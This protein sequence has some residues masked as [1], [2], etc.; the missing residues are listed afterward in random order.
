MFQSDEV[1]IIKIVINNRLDNLDLLELSEPER[2]KSAITPSTGNQIF[3]SKEL[4]VSFSAPEGWLLQ[5]PDQSTPG[6]PNVAVVG[7]KIDE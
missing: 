6:T 2:T 3:E 4:D 5:Q 1:K 7:P